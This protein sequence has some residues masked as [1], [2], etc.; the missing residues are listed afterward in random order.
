MQIKRSDEDK[1]ACLLA[2]R[3]LQQTPEWATFEK[4]CRRY[5]NAISV[6]MWRES[7]AQLDKSSGVIRGIEMALNVDELL[8][9]KK[10]V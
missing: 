2:I 10:K 9:V 6:G 8:I 4:E 5:Q 1:L 7:G 3:T